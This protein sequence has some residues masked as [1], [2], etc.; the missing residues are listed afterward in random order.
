[1]SIKDFAEYFKFTERQVVN[2]LARLRSEGRVGEI[3]SRF[4]EEN[5]SFILTNLK[6][7]GGSMS[8]REVASVVGSDA[9]GVTDWYANHRHDNDL[10]YVD[11]RNYGPLTKRIKH[12]K[13]IKVTKLVSEEPLTFEELAKTI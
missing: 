4:S 12:G 6:A 5:K 2:R 7:A 1:M 8:A 11:P 9:K 3:S 10:P 13:G